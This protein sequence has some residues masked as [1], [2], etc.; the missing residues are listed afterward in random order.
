MT[1]PTDF[2]IEDGNTLELNKRYQITLSSS[3]DTTGEGNNGTTYFI[4]TMPKR[5]VLI[6]NGSAITSRSI[7]GMHEITNPQNIVYIPHISGNDTFRYNIRDDSHTDA[8]NIGDS[9]G[10]IQDAVVSSNNGV[11]IDGVIKTREQLNNVPFN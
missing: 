9:F 5:G 8:W 3:V 10:D 7:H 4:T 2:S 1:T 6:V 11:K